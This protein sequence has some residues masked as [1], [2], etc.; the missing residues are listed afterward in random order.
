MFFVKK[1]KL[2]STDPLNFKCKWYAWIL[3]PEIVK[4]LSQIT[5]EY[6][7]FAALDKKQFLLSFCQ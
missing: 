6:T 1:E 3:I 4:S 2:T 5:L 7:D